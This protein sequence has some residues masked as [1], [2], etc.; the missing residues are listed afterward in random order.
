MGLFVLSHLFVVFDE[1][2]LSVEGFLLFFVPLHEF[3]DGS[4]V[5]DPLVEHGVCELQRVLATDQAA[6][7]KL[8]S[9]SFDHFLKVDIVLPRSCFLLL[10]LFFIKEIVIV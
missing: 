10:F 5:V 2:D 8:V 1:F 4:D 9:V 3:F 6:S 7:Q